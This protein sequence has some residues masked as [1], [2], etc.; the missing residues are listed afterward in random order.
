MLADTCEARARAEKPADNEQIADLVKAVFD[1]Y[2]TAGQMNNTPLTFRDL[3][4]ARKSFERVLQNMYHPRVLYPG[5]K[6]EQTDDKSD[7]K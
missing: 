6:K 1:M 7:T 3:S 4:T 5:Q 2:T